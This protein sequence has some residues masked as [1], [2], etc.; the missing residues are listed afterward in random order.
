[1]TQ[2]KMMGFHG[3]SNFLRIWGLILSIRKWALTNCLGGTMDGCGLTPT[4]PPRNQLSIFSKSKNKKYMSEQNF[5]ANNHTFTQSISLSWETPEKALENPN[6]TLLMRFLLLNLKNG[7]GG[8]KPPFEI[9]YR[10]TQIY[11]FMGKTE[12]ENT[13][14]RVGEYPSMTPSSRD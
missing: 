13:G 2:W 12:V 11:N 14:Q 1:M 5:L 10:T 3:L 7:I 9:P 4:L 8:G 6:Y